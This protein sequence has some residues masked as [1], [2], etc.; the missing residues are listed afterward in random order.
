[1]KI[2]G[3]TGG[4]GAGKTTAL[5]ALESL[6]ALIIDAD[7]VYHELTAR[8]AP[9]R[10][11]LEARFGSVYGPDGCLDRKKLGNIV[12]QDPKALEDLNRLVHHYVG[13]EIDR[14]LTRA[15]EE[16]YPAA[17]IDAIEL[18]GSGLGDKC[19]VTVA[20]TA[21]VEIRIR[22]IMAREGISEE[23]AKLRAMAQRDE[24][25]FRKHCDYTL[26]NGEESPE[27]FALRAGHFFRELLGL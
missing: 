3:I 12:F 4:T 22:R 26:E 16:G 2:I 27:A 9:M 11:D 13:A 14:R 17:A 24:A 6:G 5:R 19:D 21:P 1:M 7:Q 10:R 20:V 23:Y 15:R 25:Y 8:S 18:L